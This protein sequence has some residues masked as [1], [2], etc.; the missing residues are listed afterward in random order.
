V[1]KLNEIAEKFKDIAHFLTIYISEA[2]PSDVWPLG[3]TVC[4]DQHKTI[5]DRIKAAKEQ[6]I[7]KR[8]CKIPILIDSM[9]NEFDNEYHGWPERFYVLKGKFVDLLGMP[10]QEDKGF[11]RDEI[12]KYLKKKKSKERKK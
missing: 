4:I 6:L 7:E 8:S 10:S 12:R 9:D 1:P 5:D 2:H 11:N 3:R